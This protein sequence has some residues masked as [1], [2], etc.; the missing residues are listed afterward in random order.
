MK[1]KKSAAWMAAERYFSSKG[2]TYRT[3]THPPV[4]TVA[5]GKKYKIKVPGVGCKSLFLKE[6]KGNRYFLYTLPGV[7]RANLKRLAEFLHVKR[8]TFATA[9]E[10]ERFLKIK[11]GSVSPLS[12]LN[13]KEKKV[14][15][16]IDQEVISAE[17]I[18][19]HPNDNRASVVLTQEMFQLFLE[20]LDRPYYLF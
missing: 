14:E 10:L 16:V 9:D 12:I 7:K 8:L 15:L 11:P 18:N 3:Y 19:L 13:D 4:F 5:D 6:V 20:S 1:S 17:K 2:I